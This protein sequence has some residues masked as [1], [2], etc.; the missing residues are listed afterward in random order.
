MALFEELAYVR[1][2][3]DVGGNACRDNVTDAALAGDGIIGLAGPA[4]SM[5]RR[6]AIG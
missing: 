4:V 3:A 5:C 2:D 6:S 1:L